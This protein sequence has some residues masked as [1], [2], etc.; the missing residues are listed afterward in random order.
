M[1]AQPPAPHFSL[2]RP[3]SI[4]RWVESGT[5]ILAQ[6]GTGPLIRKENNQQETEKSLVNDIQVSYLCAILHKEARLANS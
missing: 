3:Y 6:S 4:N 1:D 2:F 5:L